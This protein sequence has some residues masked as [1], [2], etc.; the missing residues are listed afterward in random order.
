MPF[1]SLDAYK[2]TL[3]WSKFTTIKQGFG[4]RIFDAPKASNES[5]VFNQSFDLTL[6]NPNVIGK[7][8]Y[9]IVPQSNVGVA[10]ENEVHDVYVYTGPIKIS[11]SCTVVAYVSDGTNYCEPISLEFTRQYVG[12]EN[13]LDQVLSANDNEEYIINTA[14]YGHYHDGTYLYASTKGNSGSSKNTFNEDKKSE[15]LSDKEADFNQEAGWLSQA[16]HLTSSEKVSIAAIW[17]L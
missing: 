13:G 4:N 12:T 16:C 6:T 2:N 10:T 7:I 11:S 8:Y 9:Y 14:L 15:E 5:G 3:P 1:G 17:Q